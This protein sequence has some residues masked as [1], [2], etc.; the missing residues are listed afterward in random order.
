MNPKNAEIAKGLVDE[1][2]ILSYWDAVKHFSTTDLI[3][4]FDTNE[5]RPA[6]AKRT[7]DLFK[8]DLPEFLREKFSKPASEHAKQLTNATASF[9]FVVTFED[10]VICFPVNAQRIGPAADA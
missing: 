10:E 2:L 5:G 6:M 9:W 4:Y 7:T 3:V 8:Q 1:H